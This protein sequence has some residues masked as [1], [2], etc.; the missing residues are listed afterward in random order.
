MP[1]EVLIKYFETFSF[2]SSSGG[3]KD[4]KL[5]VK[6]KPVTKRRRNGSKVKKENAI[7]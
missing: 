4:T 2:R 3:Q 5:L 7:E 1:L 6:K